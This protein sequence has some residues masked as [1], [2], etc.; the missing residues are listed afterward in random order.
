MAKN[1]IKGK[2]HSHCKGWGKRSN[3]YSEGNA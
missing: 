2:K 3:C 1:K